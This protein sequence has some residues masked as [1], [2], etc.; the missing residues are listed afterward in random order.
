M[1][2]SVVDSV[3]KL[4]ASCCSLEFQPMKPVSW[5]VGSSICKPV[6][7][8]GVLSNSLARSIKNVNARAWGMSTKEIRYSLDETRVARVRLCGGE[9]ND[10]IDELLPQAR[11]GA[12]VC[13][14]LM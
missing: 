1:S 14:L 7:I 2:T 12:R 10:L 3:N 13:A 5:C 8:L 9:L 11:E 4:T 6:N